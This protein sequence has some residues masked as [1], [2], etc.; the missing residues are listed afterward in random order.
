VRRFSS[1]IMRGKSSVKAQDSN[2]QDIGHSST[3]IVESTTQ[4]TMTRSW[5][6]RS[7]SL[8]ALILLSPFDYLSAVTESPLCHCP[9]ALAYGLTPGSSNSASFRSRSQSP[10]IRR[11]IKHS[12]YAHCTLTKEIAPARYSTY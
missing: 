6:I 10:S 7:L 9:S 3:I 2:S 8:V 4:S 1:T 11:R 12:S 5:S